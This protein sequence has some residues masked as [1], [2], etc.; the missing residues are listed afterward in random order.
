MNSFNVIS[1]KTQN[2]IKELGPEY[3]GLIEK[4][5]VVRNLAKPEL[6]PGALGPEFQK[7]LD[8]RAWLEKYATKVVPQPTLGDPPPKVSGSFF[9]ANIQQ[10]DYNRGFF[11][12]VVLRKTYNKLLGT[13]RNTAAL[14][15]ENEKFTI[16][17]TTGT[18]KSVSLG[19]EVGITIAAETDI[20]FS[21]ITTEMGFNVKTDQT[22]TISKEQGITVEM[23]VNPQEEVSLYQLTFNW[24]IL[25]GYVQKYDGGKYV[26]VLRVVDVFDD[27]TSVTESFYKPLV[28]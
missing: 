6:I 25:E 14:G 1:E 23:T 5:D 21:S 3:A 22:H 24:V 17:G 4:P 11:K 27:P 8:R 7:H 12:A 28:A 2:L 16:T 10:P 13:Q 19:F 26:S 15:D 9:G 20:G 18:S